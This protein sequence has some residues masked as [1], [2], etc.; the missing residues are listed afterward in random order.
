MSC[1]LQINVYSF[2]QHWQ[3]T[4]STLL[5]ILFVLE[6][7]SSNVKAICCMPIRST[8][9]FRHY[10]KHRSCWPLCARKTV[11]RNYFISLHRD[12]RIHFET[13]VIWCLWD[14]S[15]GRKNC[16]VQTSPLKE[17]KAVSLWLGLFTNEMLWLFCCTSIVQRL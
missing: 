17:I 1:D 2:E 11:N 8:C 4:M 7:V 13:S 10:K 5:L 16:K 9:H 6:M 14:G 12:S 15:R 3:W